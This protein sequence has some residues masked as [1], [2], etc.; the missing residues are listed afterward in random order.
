MVRKPDK[1]H[2]QLFLL[3]DNPEAWMYLCSIFY[4]QSGWPVH[5]I[6]GDDKLDAAVYA[7]TYEM[8]AP[9]AREWPLFTGVTTLSWEE[10]W[11]EM[12]AVFL[13]EIPDEFNVLSREIIYG[14]KGSFRELVPKSHDQIWGDK[15]AGK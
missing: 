11:K 7:T 9:V 10:M 8:K 4:P 15:V 12:N 5:E 14:Y 2:T 1:D 13:L 3:A 6:S